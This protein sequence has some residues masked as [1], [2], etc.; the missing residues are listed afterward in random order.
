MILDN[1][2]MPCESFTNPVLDL[3]L[4][5]SEHRANF[6]IHMLV[7]TMNLLKSICDAKIAVNC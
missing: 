2:E 6:S 3:E 1:P 7:H 5:T 4:L